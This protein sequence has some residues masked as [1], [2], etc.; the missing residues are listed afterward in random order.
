M[1][2][3][4]RT[5]RTRAAEAARAWREQYAYYIAHKQRCEA[6][7]PAAIAAALEALGPT[8]DPLDVN[9]VIGNDT[10]TD[11]GACDECGNKAA[12]LYRFGANDYITDACVDCIMRAAL[13]LRGEGA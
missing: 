2:T 5:A 4:V 13:A 9:A 1:R 6:R 12:A 8:P 11:P 3:K 7:D 10:W